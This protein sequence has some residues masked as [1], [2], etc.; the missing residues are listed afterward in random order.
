MRGL[1][2]MSVA[3]GVAPHP[4]SQ[5]TMS[6]SQGLKRHVIV[7]VSKRDANKAV[8]CCERSQTMLISDHEKAETF[9]F[10]GAKV[11]GSPRGCRRWLQAALFS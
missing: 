1:D 4:L 11:I 9:H 2:F 6:T 3:L 8:L 7:N 5:R 10:E